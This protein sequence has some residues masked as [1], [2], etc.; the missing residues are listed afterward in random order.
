MVERTAAVLA[1]IAPA[2]RQSAEAARAV[3][4]MTSGEPAAKRHKDESVA[5]QA[6][7]QVNRVS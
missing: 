6:S 2:Q 3:V 7:V 1:P 4:A 5:E